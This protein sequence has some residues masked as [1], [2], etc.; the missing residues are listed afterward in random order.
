[1]K[2]KTKGKPS[3]VLKQYGTIHNGSNRVTIILIID[4]IYRDGISGFVYIAELYSTSDL[5]AA[6]P[7]LDHYYINQIITV[8]LHKL[9]ILII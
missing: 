8:S 6:S 3:K 5:K 7:A 4:S 1:M 9:F 2:L